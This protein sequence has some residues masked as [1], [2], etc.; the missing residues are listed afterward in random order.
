[1]KIKEYL[2]ENIEKYQVPS[3]RVQ[4]IFNTVDGAEINIA[5][6]DRIVALIGYLTNEIYRYVASIEAATGPEIVELMKEFE[7]ISRMMPVYAKHASFELA[8]SEYDKG[9][10]KAWEVISLLF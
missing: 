4:N 3:K 8:L 2:T 9:N 5:N 6:E 1:M 10:R 7:E